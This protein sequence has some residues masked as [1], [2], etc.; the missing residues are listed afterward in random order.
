M[1][2]IFVYGLICES[3]LRQFDKI[4]LPPI[5]W[6]PIYKPFPAL[7]LNE[8][9]SPWL[10][11]LCVSNINDRLSVFGDTKKEST[12]GKRYKFAGTKEKPFEYATGFY[13]WDTTVIFDEKYGILISNG[14]KIKYELVINNVEVIKYGTVKN[15]SIVWD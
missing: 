11:Q 2:S 5:D 8:I 14:S 12:S 1:E 15:W 6:K 13:I 3:L 9:A 10:K 4:N 7:E